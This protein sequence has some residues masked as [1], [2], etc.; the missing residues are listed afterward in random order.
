MLTLPVVCVCV[1]LDFV[2]FYACAT[3]LVHIS[4]KD[5]VHG[6]LM[7]EGC[8]TVVVFASSG[9]DLQLDAAGMGISASDF[10]AMVLNQKRV[11]GPLHVRDEFLSQREALNRKERPAEPG[12]GK[13][14][15]LL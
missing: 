1:C 4:S 11:E 10:E 15:H 14:V 13:G 2:V 12:S 6:Q 8:R 7:C 5:S 3:I 9:G